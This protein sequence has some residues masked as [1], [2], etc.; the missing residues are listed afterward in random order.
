MMTKAKSYC[1]QHRVN[2]LCYN[3][4]TK[5]EEVSNWQLHKIEEDILKN[6]LP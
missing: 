4:S 3:C 5:E 1:C 2:T 6:L